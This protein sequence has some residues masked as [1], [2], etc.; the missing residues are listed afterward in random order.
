M[1][2]TW[3]LSGS[4]VEAVKALLDAHGDNPSVKDRIERNLRP[5][6]PSATREEFWRNL[7]VCLTTSRQ[8]SGPGTR[9]AALAGAAPFPLS[10]ELCAKQGNVQAFVAGVLTR[11]GLRFSTR[12]AG[13]VATNLARL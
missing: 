3:Q 9:V 12:I 6:K 8:P 2:I 10:Y 13:F 1:K 5:E 4:D 7:V 11:Y